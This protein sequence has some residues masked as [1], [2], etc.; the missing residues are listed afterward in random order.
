MLILWVATVT[1]LF[2][3]PSKF[4]STELDRDPTI[5][6]LIYDIELKM[7]PKGLSEDATQVAEGS[8]AA[9]HKLL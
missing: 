5:T 6:D 1:I 7:L 8:S 3:V 9:A 4:S 2:V